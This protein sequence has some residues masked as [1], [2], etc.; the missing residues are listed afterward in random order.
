[1]L[2]LFYRRWK[3]VILFVVGDG[4]VIGYDCVLGIGVDVNQW[5]VVSLLGFYVVVGGDVISVYWL[6]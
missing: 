3:S 6:S 4:D 5:K 2:Y 1:M